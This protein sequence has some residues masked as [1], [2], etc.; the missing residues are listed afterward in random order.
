M[1]ASV[2]FSFPT[3]WIPDLIRQTKIKVCFFD[4]FDFITQE[5]KEENDQ[6]R[7]KMQML[8]TQIAKLNLKKKVRLPK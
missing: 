5:K 2:G 8:Q 4:S 6:T 1:Q 7:Q 3:P